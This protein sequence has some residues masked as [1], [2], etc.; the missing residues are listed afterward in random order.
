MES[1][2]RVSLAQVAHNSPDRNLGPPGGWINTKV[3][4]L[5]A[6][7]LGHHAGHILLLSHQSF[8]HRL[9]Q[10]I[11]LHLSLCTFSSRF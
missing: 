6:S 7:F 4:G 5:N 3:V 11:R 10:L 8:K 9:T 1:P 2:K